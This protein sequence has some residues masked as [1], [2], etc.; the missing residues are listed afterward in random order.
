[1]CPENYK[2]NTSENTRKE[3]INRSTL[4]GRERGRCLERLPW[5]FSLGLQAKKRGEFSNPTRERQ[6]DDLFAKDAG[7]LRST[8]PTTGN[9]AGVALSSPVVISNCRLVKP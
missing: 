5:A 6:T 1:M 7:K 3:F 4:W 9:D 2:G 8:R